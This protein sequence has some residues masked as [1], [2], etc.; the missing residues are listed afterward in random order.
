MMDAPIYQSD[1]FRI[2]AYKVLLCS[3]RVAHDCA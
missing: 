2:A 1:A 3:N